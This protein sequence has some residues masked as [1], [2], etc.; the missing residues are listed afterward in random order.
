AQDQSD[1]KFIDAQTLSKSG[2]WP[3]STDNYHRVQADERPKLTK[4][5]QGLSLNSSGINITFQTN[6]KQIVAKWKVFKYKGGSGMTPIAINGLD[7]YGWNGKT[8]Q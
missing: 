5:V 2:Q 4:A 7:L 8:W 3:R 1:L 6:S